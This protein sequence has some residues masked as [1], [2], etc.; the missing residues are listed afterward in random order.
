MKIYPLRNSRL[1]A[2]KIVKGYPSLSIGNITTQQFSD[3]EIKVEFGESIRGKKVILLGSLTKSDDIIEIMM[4]ADAA[5]RASA[6]EIIAIIPYLPYMRQDRKDTPRTAIGARVIANMIETSGIDQVITLD[7]HASQIEGF[8]NIPTTH[9]NGVA[10]FAPFIKANFD[11]DNTMIVSPDVGGAKRAKKFSKSLGLNL[12]II[13][14]EREIANEVSNM[15]LLGNVKGKD[16]IL[17]DDM[18]D[19]AGS[20]V[21]AVELL[22]EEG[23]NKI[24]ACISHGVLSGPARDRIH[25]SKLEKLYITDSIDNHVIEIAGVSINIVSCAT[26]LRT[27]IMRIKEKKS[28]NELMELV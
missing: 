16:V 14:K 10:V 21:K 9:L 13:N 2:E 3:A 22:K 4:A 5:K 12:A 7:L 26:I 23:A 27:T 25:G 20:L 19:T 1:L 24:Y 8:F 15:E 18:V 17:V 28:V 11:K 6:K